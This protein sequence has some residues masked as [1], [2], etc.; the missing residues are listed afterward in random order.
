V[1]RLVTTLA[2]QR[3]ELKAVAETLAAQ[4]CRDWSRRTTTVPHGSH[5][6]MVFAAIGY[7]LNAVLIDSE[8]RVRSAVLQRAPGNRTVRAGPQ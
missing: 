4:T 6:I 3:Q 8:V 5:V 7:E 1:E 2:G